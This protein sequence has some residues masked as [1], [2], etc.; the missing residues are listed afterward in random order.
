MATSNNDRISSQ[1]LLDTLKGLQASRHLGSEP[2]VETVSVEYPAVVSPA[3]GTYNDMTSFREEMASKAVDENRLPV[4]IYTTPSN[5]NTNPV[6][7]LTINEPSG[8]YVEADKKIKWHNFYGYANEEVADE[9]T[10]TGYMVLNMAGMWAGYHIE[11]GTPDNNQYQ[12]EMP[13]YTETTTTKTKHPIK[14]DYVP[15]ADWNVNDPDADG[16]VQG[17]T[18]WVEQSLTGVIP[19]AGTYNSL[20][21]FQDALNS[22]EPSVVYVCDEYNVSNFP[23][24]LPEFSGEPIAV[25][26]KEFNIDG[27]RVLAPSDWGGSMENPPEYLFVFKHETYSP[28]NMVIGV[29]DNKQ[30]RWKA[31]GE[32]VHKLDRKFYDYTEPF[33]PTG[34]TKHSDIF[35][36]TISKDYG[37]TQGPFTHSYDFVKLPNGRA[38]GNVTLHVDSWDD[39]TK[40]G[41]FST[42]GTPLANP[43]SMVGGT[44]YVNGGIVFFTVE[45][46]GSNP[47]ISNP[48]PSDL[49]VVNRAGMWI[50]QMFIRKEDE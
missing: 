49:L 26:N 15:N 38:Y 6:F 17:R 3:E 12:W 50:P 23:A 9:N 42:I 32:V 35:I 18:H 19:S 11:N 45:A 43:G 4:K 44:A 31:V 16:Y 14:Q 30:Y 5:P 27:T 28:T 41:T 39:T 7:P 25:L 34:Y 21:E 46:D 29:T 10:Y 48:I 22:V 47:R 2:E 13:A 24:T 8:A 40:T 37:S 36:Q 33:D 20:Q 1:R